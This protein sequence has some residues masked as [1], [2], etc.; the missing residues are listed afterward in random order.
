MLEC[1]QGKAVQPCSRYLTLVLGEQG[2]A[3]PV[4]PFREERNQEIVPDTLIVVGIE[5]QQFLVMSNGSFPVSEGPQSLSQPIPGPHVGPG[6]K[7]APEV[8]RLFD[9]DLLTQRTLSRFHTL[10]IEFLRLSGI[11]GSLFGKEHVGI[12]TI[13]RQCERLLG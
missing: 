7:Q 12:C 2:L 5:P 1:Q 9:E 6:F 3:V 4:H 11:S 8:A 13:R 10:F